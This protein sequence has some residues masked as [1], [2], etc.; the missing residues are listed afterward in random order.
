LGAPAFRERRQRFV[1][2]GWQAVAILA[3]ILTSPDLR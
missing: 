2:S 3:I 1:A